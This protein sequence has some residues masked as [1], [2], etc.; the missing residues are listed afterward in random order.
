MKEGDINIWMSV[1]EWAIGQ[2]PG[3]TNNPNS[4]SSGEVNIIKSLVAD[5]ILHVKFVDIPYEELCEKFVLYDELLPAKL[6]HDILHHLQNIN[7]H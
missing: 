3:L 6:R 5:Y 1:I 4:W 2:V 7:D